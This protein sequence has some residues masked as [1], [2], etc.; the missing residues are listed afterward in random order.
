MDQEIVFDSVQAVIPEICDV[1]GESKVRLTIGD[2]IAADGQAATSSF[3]KP[4][5]GHPSDF[6]EYIK[7]VAECASLVITLIKAYNRFED[8]E[9]KASDEATNASGEAAD[10]RSRA[11]K[12]KSAVIGFLRNIKL[13]TAPRRPDEQQPGH[14]LP[15]DRRLEGRRLVCLVS[16]CSVLAYR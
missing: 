3:S 4:E 16:A 13:I 1:V 15:S 11:E 6:A 8:I 12:I 7:T 14:R 2:V 10:T 5:H 9:K